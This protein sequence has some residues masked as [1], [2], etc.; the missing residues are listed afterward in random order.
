MIKLRIPGRDDLPAL[1]ALCLRSKAHWGYDDAFLARC[2]AEL[3][4]HPDDLKADD[5]VM[6]DAGGV[7]LGVVQLSYDNGACF[8]EKLFVEPDHIGHG[9]GKVLFRW[10]VDAA[11]ARGVG[12]II[13]EADPDAV[14]FYTAMGCRAAGTVASGSIPGRQIP[15]LIYTTPPR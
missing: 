12:E 6:A 10:A 9:I 8:L 14:P 7:P 15:R 11:A 4:L 1:S 3:T 5:I 2:A 13:V